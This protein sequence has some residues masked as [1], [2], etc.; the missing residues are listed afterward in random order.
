MRG[1]AKASVSLDCI[2]NVIFYIQDDKICKVDLDGNITV[3][4]HVPDGRMTAFTHASADGKRLC[5]PMTDGRCLDFDQ[6]PKEA[7]WTS[8]RS[9]TLTDV[10]RKRI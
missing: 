5:V 10:S 4:N 1:W 9:T 7:A 3:L 6:R 8:A 2:N